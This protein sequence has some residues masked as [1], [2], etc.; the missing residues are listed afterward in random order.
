MRQTT[1]L[2]CLLS[3]LNAFASA[4]THSIGPNGIN[5]TASML[6]GN[7]VDIGQLELGRSGDPQLDTLAFHNTTIDPDLVLDRTFVNNQAVQ[8]ISILSPGS[9][10]PHATEVAGIIIST[11]SVAKG[12]APGAN[13]ISLAGSFTNV[14]GTPQQQIEGIY[15]QAAESA[16]TLATLAGRDVKAINLSMLRLF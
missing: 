8:N 5:S 16:N 7:S 10:L 9:N 13:L 12:V 4:S 1:L 11:D 2:I 3:F 14:G 15:T 6:T